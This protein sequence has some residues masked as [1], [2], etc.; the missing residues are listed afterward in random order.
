ME[1]IQMVNLKDQYFKIKNEINVEIQKVL[2]ECDFI[3]GKKVEEFA[4]NLK[5]YTGAKFV[6]PCA[7]GT[8]ALQIALMSLDF[9]IGD[10]IIVPAFT[11]AATAEVISILGLTPVLV[12]VDSETFCI[13]EKKIDN[14]ISKKTKAIIPVHLYGQSSDMSTILQIAK[15][16]NLK[17]IEDN[18]Q[19]LGATYTFPN[20]TSQKTG[21]IGDIGCTSFFPSKNLG[22]FGDGGAIFTNDEYLYKKIKMI[23]NHGQNTKYKHDIIGCNSRLDTIQA[24]ILDV[25]LKHLDN[26]ISLREQFASYYYKKFH[27]YN[28]FIRLPKRSNFSTHVFHQFT[29]KV[30]FNKRDSL[31]KYLEDCNIPSMVYYPFTINNQ[32]AF[33]KIIRT[34]ESL[35]ISEQLCN[36]VLSLPMHTELTF[37]QIDK[38]DNC[39]KNYFN[40]I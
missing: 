32:L 17:V 9:S 22:C 14:L 20:G 24:A 26:Y 15:K 21:T 3:N 31:K 18:A 19:A 36:E 23:A 16:Y 28:Y 1:N 34:P 27:K 2:D 10:E 40:N 33:K 30:L 13:D 5:N 11:Y 7:N 38:I 37:D 8:D 29:I 25:K 6:I 12:D 35:D 4:E 39:F